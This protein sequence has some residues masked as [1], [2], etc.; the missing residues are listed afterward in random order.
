VR[1]PTKARSIVRY[2][3]LAASVVLGAC[4]G[5]TT[6]PLAPSVATESVTSPF[7]PTEAAKNLYGVTDGTYTFTVDPRQD[8]TL[9]VGANILSLPAN[10]VCRLATSSYGMGHWDE[11]CAPETATVTITAIVKGANSSHPSIDFYPA[12]RFNPR[13]DVE[14]YFYVPK[15]VRVAKDEFLMK[16]CFDDKHNK[17]SC[18]DESLDDASLA[19]HTDRRTKMVFR[20]IKHFSG[21]I[22]VNMVDDALD[23]LY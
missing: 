16:Y 1:L 19:T 7:V 8:Q 4:A 10:S 22:I 15:G 23:L 20:R 2:T 3:V 13:N 21:Y 12:M 6:T 11:P 17:K 5:D 9:N 18:V 14:L